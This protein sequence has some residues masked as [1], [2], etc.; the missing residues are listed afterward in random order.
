PNARAGS[1]TRRPDR[2]VRPMSLLEPKASSISLRA[3]MLKAYPT[4]RVVRPSL[5]RTPHHAFHARRRGLDAAVVAAALAAG[6]GAV[7]ITS[8]ARPGGMYDGVLHRQGIL[9]CRSLHSSPPSPR[10]SPPP[11]PR[12]LPRTQLRHGRARPTIARRSKR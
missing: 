8:V 3:L 9:P 1:D 7:R 4:W 5:R 6:G 10:C 12:P 2:L 11:S